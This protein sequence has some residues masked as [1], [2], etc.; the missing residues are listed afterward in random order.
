MLRFGDVRV[1]ANGQKP[2][3]SADP[4]APGGMVRRYGLGY[5]R[6]PGVGHP[7]GSVPEV[8]LEVLN[9]RLSA[10]ALTATESAIFAALH[11]DKSPVT[12]TEWL[13]LMFL[14]YDSAHTYLGKMAVDHIDARPTPPVDTR[15]AF[16]SYEDTRVLL[17]SLGDRRGFYATQYRRVADEL[18]AAGLSAEQAQAKLIA[19]A[20]HAPYPEQWR[21]PLEA[22]ALND[23]YEALLQEAIDAPAARRAEIKTKAAELLAEIKD[24]VQPPPGAPSNA[25]PTVDAGPLMA[26]IQLGEESLALEGD[27]G[28]AAALDSALKTSPRLSRALHDPTVAH[29]QHEM[30]TQSV[31]R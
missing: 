1:F 24:L 7:P 18:A 9:S 20:G 4:L 26:A 5:Q 21:I 10:G 19:D 30:G 8:S 13:D 22:I 11:H 6:V 27:R 17:L 31:I 28:L 3:L 15:P 16:L 12:Y 23:Q 14:R 2:D 29:A 25:S